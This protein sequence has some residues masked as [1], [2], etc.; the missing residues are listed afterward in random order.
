V[1]QASWIVFLE[2]NTE[3][4]PLFARRHT[5]SRA[6]SGRAAD[7]SKPKP[8]K[9][10]QALLARAAHENENDCLD[11]KPLVRPLRVESLPTLRSAEETRLA[12]NGAPSGSSSGIH[13]P[14]EHWA[15]GP[16]RFNQNYSD[17]NRSYGNDWAAGH[18]NHIHF[19]KSKGTAKC[20]IGPCK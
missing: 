1:S 18:A 4:A 10:A 13:C 3:G 5:T 2:W 20:K 16:K 17:N 8:C 14:F 12:K 9:V 15:A 11:A 6:K 7:T 19:G